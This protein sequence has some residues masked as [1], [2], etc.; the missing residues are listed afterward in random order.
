MAAT[1]THKICS[2]CNISKPLEHFSRQAQ[3]RDG[4]RGQCKECRRLYQSNYAVSLPGVATHNRYM[5]KRRLFRL[6]R[7]SKLKETYDLSKDDFYL[8]LEK[9]GGKCAICRSEDPKNKKGVFYVDHCHETGKVR[10]LLCHKCNYVLGVFRDQVAL[11]Y[12]AI[13]YLKRHSH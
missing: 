2:S 13:E 12:N 5:F 3:Y 9:Q 4:H 11:F 10:G 8:M 7:W 6:S 1:T